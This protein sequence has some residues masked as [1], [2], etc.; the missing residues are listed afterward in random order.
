MAKFK[1]LRDVYRFPGFAPR[2]RISGIFGNWP[3]VVI[4]LHRRQKKRYAESVVRGMA[5]IMT[6]GR[7]ESAIFLAAIDGYT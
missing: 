2:S 6:R 7:A 4:S 1:Q 5:V 3:A